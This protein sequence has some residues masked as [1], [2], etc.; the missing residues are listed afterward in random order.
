[1]IIDSTGIRPA[2][3][4]LEAIEKMP[5][6]SNVEELQAFLGMT[7]YLRQFIQNYSITAAPLTDL[8]R[9]KE[10]AS[11]KA[12]KFPIAWGDKEAE[13]FRQL[14]Q[15]LTSPTVLA[16]PDWNS[17][18][19]VQTDAS[20][21][22]AGAVLLQPMGRE[23]RVLA[24][25]S[26]RFSKTDSRRG[27]TERE[28]MAVLWAIKHFRQ[29][30]AGRRFT[31]V[32]DC[33][34]LTWLFRSR[35]LDPKLHRWALSL[36]A[37]DIDLRWRA[38]SA[39]LV[40]DCL[41]RL[42]HQTQTDS[43]IDDSFRDD[44][45]VA[46]PNTPSQQS[47]PTLDGV[48]LQDLDP[49]DEP[50][51][52]TKQP[53]EA[54][55]A[56]ASAATAC[57]LRELPF[58]TCATLEDEQTV[59]RR[60]GRIRQPSVR[61]HDTD[62]PQTYKKRPEQGTA[63]R[64]S[65]RQALMPIDMPPKE[66]HS[67]HVASTPI[68]VPPRDDTDLTASSATTTEIDD[69]LLVGGEV[70]SSSTTADAPAETASTIERALKSLTETSLLTAQQN[71]DPFLKQIIM[72][73]VEN[74]TCPE[75]DRYL[76]DEKNLVWYTPND[77]KPVLAVPRSMAPVLLALVHTLHG[78]AGVGATL[79]LVRTHFHWP[80]IA[81][82]TRLYVASCGCNRRKRSPSQKI[83]TMPGRTVEPWETLEVDILSMGTTSRIGNKYILLVVDRASRF[84][85]HFLYF[86]RELRK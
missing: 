36:Q 48:A 11:K 9:N 13:A 51:S 71:N 70:A 46:N 6:P 7:G 30:V 58:T 63:D 26:H 82:D 14:K 75:H 67:N 83:A 61:L 43:H 74:K 84:R 44:T 20:S 31:L 37:Y 27:P 69:V 85:L 64:R 34:A 4:K 62:I 77:S 8:L 41:S 52:K 49:F 81:R 10:F 68:T 12:R 39:N 5:P 45:S 33:S 28:C 47:G 3:S 65:R 80:T 72:S 60:S 23:E 19:I 76:I 66:P 50:T 38:G 56:E 32:T 1:M 17:T 73:G 57:A 18:F 42:P 35:N 53:I 16:F 78:H 2:P 54:A 59:V 21:A 79:A 22:G 86:P 25:A 15:T 24:F 40:P 29:Y 55:T